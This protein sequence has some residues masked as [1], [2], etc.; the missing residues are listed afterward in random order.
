MDLADEFC[1][2]ESGTHAAK[3]ASLNLGSKR[4]NA[5]NKLRGALRRGEIVLKHT[6]DGKVAGFK[7]APASTK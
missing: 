5:G 4:M 3:Y 1:P 6:K 2:L 7:A